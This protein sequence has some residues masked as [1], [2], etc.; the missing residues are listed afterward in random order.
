MGAIYVEKIWVIPNP[1]VG[2]MTNGREANKGNVLTRATF[3]L[4]EASGLNFIGNLEGYDLPNGVANVIVTDGL[5]GNIATKMTEALSE[6]L[7]DRLAQRFAASGLENAAN[8][9]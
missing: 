9:I 5:W 1:T 4:L 3:P 7:L 6:Q 2:L 8:P